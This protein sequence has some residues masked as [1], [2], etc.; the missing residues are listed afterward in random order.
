VLHRL[1]LSSTTSYLGDKVV[2]SIQNM[3]QS[4]AHQ[5]E[6]LSSSHQG[7]AEASAHQG[8]AMS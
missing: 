6:D 3:A 1:R 4:S 7:E 2:A 8:E 5:G